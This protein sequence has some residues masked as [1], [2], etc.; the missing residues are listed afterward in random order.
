MRERIKG[1]G[2]PRGAER[3]APLGLH[4]CMQTPIQ[5]RRTLSFE[6]DEAPRLLLNHMP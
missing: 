5:L 6:L 3:S 4:A 2:L 1:A